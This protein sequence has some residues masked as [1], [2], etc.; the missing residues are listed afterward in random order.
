MAQIRKIDRV[1]TRGHRDPL[2][3]VA[4]A[5][6]MQCSAIDDRQ[7]TALIIEIE[8][9]FAL[10]SPRPDGIEGRDDLP[11]PIPRSERASVM[12]AIAGIDNAAYDLPDCIDFAR[13]VE[14]RQ[15]FWLEEP[16]HWYLQPTDFARLSAATPIPARSWRTRADAFHGARFYCR[17]R[18]PL[19]AVRRDP[20]RRLHRGLAHSSSRR[21]ARGSC[22]LPIPRQSC[23]TTLCLQRHVVCSGSS[24]TVG[25]RLTRWLMASSASIRNCAMVTFTSATA[26][27]S[28]SRSI[29]LLSI[30]TACGHR[31]GGSVSLPSELLRLPEAVVLLPG[32]PTLNF[33]AAWGA[34]HEECRQYGCR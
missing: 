2:C 4:S 7:R 30:G 1:C 15:I 26:P 28:A 9:L 17:G 18:H 14:P 34:A 13:A 20:R 24:H 32:R 5:G 21:A 27:A 19:G 6:V 10:T 22:S 8:K 23:T 31:L 25:R 12:A 3:V 33:P 11:P 16:L 29:G